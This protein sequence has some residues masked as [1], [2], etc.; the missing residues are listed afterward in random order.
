M[1]TDEFDAF[2]DG[3]DY[4]LFVVT[5]HDG[6]E[7]DGCLVGFATQTSIDPPRLLVCL[8]VANRTTRVAAGSPVLAV[9]VLGERDHPLAALF[10]G[11]TG[12]E[13]DKLARCD[14]RPG[15]HGVPL[16]ADAPRLVVGRV[17]ERIPLGDHVG[18][19]LEPVSVRRDAGTGDD[20][21]EGGGTAPLTLADVDDVEPGH[22]AG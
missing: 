16:L 2:V 20:D 11:E 1:T 17:L 19:L 7:R 4:P 10:G 3:L 18:H 21:G 9:H 22:A 8:S 14:W 5:A 12:D 15:P 13:T 6:D